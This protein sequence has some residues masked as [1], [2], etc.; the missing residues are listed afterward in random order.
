M[1]KFAK[2]R[3]GLLVLFGALAFTPHTFS[4]VALVS[5]PSS[6][7]KLAP[8]SYGA[9]NS[10]LRVQALTGGSGGVIFLKASAVTNVKVKVHR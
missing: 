2:S 5:V 6:S 8:Q 4:S 9:V 1:R 3:Y 7:A 10:G